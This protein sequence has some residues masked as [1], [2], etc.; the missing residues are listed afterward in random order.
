MAHVGEEFALCAIRDL[1]RLLRAPRLLRRRF[2]LRQ[3]LEQLSAR[4]LDAPDHAVEFARKHAD[5]VTAMKIETSR[6]F[7]A[8]ADRHRVTR[9]ARQRRQYQAI[10]DADEHGKNDDGRADQI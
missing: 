4:L 10:Q 9:N 6:Q 2:Q 1:G 7:R 8:L 5:L 3:M